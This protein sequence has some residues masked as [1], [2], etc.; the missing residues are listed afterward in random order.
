MTDQ[1]RTALQA[2][3]TEARDV[4]H[5]LRLGRAEVSITSGGKTVT[6]QNA[7]IGELKNYIAEMERALGVAVRRGPLTF[8]IG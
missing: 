5:Q 4:L 2:Q 1:E 3:L 8:R 7:N 6:Y